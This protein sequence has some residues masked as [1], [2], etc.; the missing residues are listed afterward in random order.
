MRRLIS[1]G[2]R[3]G[4]AVSLALIVLALA[5]LR[6][7]FA[8]APLGVGALPAAVAALAC[9]IV[10]AL[11]G[12][13][14]ASVP[15]R[16]I[17]APLTAAAAL[18]A[19]VVVLRGATGIAAVVSERGVLLGRTAPGPIDLIGRDLRSW[20]PRRATVEWRGSLR[21]PA[22]GRFLLWIEGV[23]AADAIVAGRPLLSASGSPFHAETAIVLGRG[24]T[25]LELHFEQ[26]GP[27]PACASAGRDRMGDG[28]S[29]RRVS[30]DPPHPP[31]GGG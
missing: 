21:V 28:R 7:V 9:G 4:L 16:R 27:G 5:R 6:P 12:S 2:A 22:S 17:A 19:L 31:G 23:G 14:R 15:W 24:P 29:C 10:A 26:R 25:T 8:A 1:L 20:A 11:T 30:W 13:Q 3:S 18:L